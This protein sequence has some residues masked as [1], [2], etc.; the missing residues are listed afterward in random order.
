MARHF[1]KIK[2]KG[3]HKETPDCVTIEFDIPEELQTS[4]VYKQGQNITIK[5]HLDD[6]RRTYSISSSP[7]ENKLVVAV[8]RVPKGV[9]SNY[10]LETLKEGDELEIMEP[11]GSFFSELNSTQKKNYLFFAAGSGITPIISIIKTILQIEPQS[12]ISLVYGNRNISSIIFREELEGLKNLY[13]ERLVL[14]HIISREPTDSPL[15][16]GRIDEDKLKEL[17]KIINYKKADEIFICGPE[18]MIFTIRD[19]L[20]AKGIEEKKIHFELF[21]TQGMQVSGSGEPKPKPEKEVVSEES[22][23]VT[24]LLDGRT[25]EVQVPYKNPTI[26]DA[27]LNEDINLPYSCKG[28]VCTTCRAKLL[29][30]KV[31]MDCNYGLEDYEVEQGYILTC[32]SHPRTPVCR[33]DYDQ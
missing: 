13:M 11:A 6:I 16:T 31:E 10:A 28:G 32:Q 29:E 24:I 20:I 25:Y 9:F 19:F 26:L 3:I 22:S 15:N 27:G 7:L 14:T 8:K 2:V 30:G 23:V 17:E 5:T 21:I 12:T 33:V 4:F 1:H 18:K